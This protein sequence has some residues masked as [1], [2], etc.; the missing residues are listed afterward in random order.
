V[1][2]RAEGLNPKIKVLDFPRYLDRFTDGNFQAMLIS[3]FLDY[4][5]PMSVLSY[6]HKT[7]AYKGFF[8]ESFDLS[9]GF[10]ALSKTIEPARRRN[11]YSNLQNRILGVRIVN[12]IIFG[13]DA[14]TLWG[15]RVSHVPPHPMGIHTLRFS[16]LEMA[17]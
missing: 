15:P 13:N 5:D 1:G 14:S 7:S 2:W 10:D 12:P 3:K 8:P 11:L 17:Q 16:E 4:P 6:F 9:N